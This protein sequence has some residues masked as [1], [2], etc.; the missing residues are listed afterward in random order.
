MIPVPQRSAYQLIYVSLLAPAALLWVELAMR[1]ILLVSH[2]RNAA[3]GIT[4]MLI[5]NGVWFVQVLEGDEAAV[6]ACY[7]RIEKDARHHR[8][9]VRLRKPVPER[10]FSRWSMCGMTLSLLEDGLLQS[11]D[12]VFDIGQASPG[13]LLQLMKRVADKHGLQLDA[14]HAELGA[15]ISSRQGWL[16][17]NEG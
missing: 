10:A 5:S 8:P 2:R 9:T 3:D 13:A 11:P 1:E 12:I 14:I 15:E 4:G 7:A 17:P 16:R 6:E